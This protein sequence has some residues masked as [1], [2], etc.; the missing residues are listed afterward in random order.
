[1]LF[2]AEHQWLDFENS[3]SGGSIAGWAQAPCESEVDEGSPI[4]ALLLF[5]CWEAKPASWYLLQS[6]V[7]ASKS[8][9][10]ARHCS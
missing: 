2:Q 3:K 10:K 1:V 8:C 6:L 9:G 5:L 7:P 4:I